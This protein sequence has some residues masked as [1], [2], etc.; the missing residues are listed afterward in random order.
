MSEAD[1]L[2]QAREARAVAEASRERVWSGASFIRDLF[3]GRFRLELIESLEFQPPTRPEFIQ[4]MQTLRGFLLSSVDPVEIDATG[5]Y[6][7]DVIQ[8]LRELGAFGL[9]IPKEYGGLGMSH[10]E[11][12]HVM[13]LLGSH[14]ANVTAL[15]SAHQAIGVPQPV[16]LF[17][18]EAQ[19]RQF[20]PR[21][22]KGAIS[23]FALTE[24]AVGSD[25]ARIQSR[26]ALS[27]D[28]TH[29]ILDGD[30]LWCTNGTL[31][32]LLVVMARDPETGRIN[33]F[34]VETSWPGVT[35]EYRCRFM[36][37]RAL[38]NAY[39]TFRQVRV[40]REN[41]IGP[42]GEGLRVALTTL[43]TGRLT[44]PAATAGGA[45][46]CVEIVRKWSSAR[47]Q[48][49]QE[50][51]KHEAVALLNAKI[52]SSALAMESV[53][54]AVGEIAD[55]E[56]F[57]IRLEAAAA[58]EWNTVRAWHLIDDTLQVRGGRG[59]ETELSLAARGEPAIGVERAL[60][61]ARIN[62]I[63][64]GSSEIMHLFMAREAVD[65][66]LEV[67]GA[68]VDP[69]ASMAQRLAALP[70]AIGFY[71]WWYPSRWIGWGR[72][73][74]YRG[75]GPLAKHLRF[76]D[77]C[78][79]R[80]ARAV[81]HGMAVYRAKLEHRQAFLFR[82]VDVAMELFVVTVTL[83]RAQLLHERDSSA[84]DGVLEL[85]DLFAAGARERIRQHLRG[86][87]HNADSAGYRVGRELL[88]GRYEW[89]ERGI[90]GI[91]EQADELT[92]MSLEDLLAEHAAPTEEP[93]PAPEPS[94]QSQVGQGSEDRRAG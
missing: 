13:A 30:K 5:E 34:V 88:A 8:G 3:M 31:A 23:A 92:P 64:E 16:L 83:R 80:L 41:L 82:A 86:L 37:L 67:A 63:F 4:F 25:P 50:I 27:D 61:D 2:I 9:K 73:P 1:E 66:H 93:G 42:V 52:A 45:K 44:L 40:P 43:N 36:G 81:F 65:E 51:G 10:I 32:E 29:Y 28:H 54:H 69:G 17:G 89:L 47:V 57:D 24:P 7:P 48:W 60:R 14:D 46:K 59:Y 76:V 70:R 33:A 85:A 55:R 18:T 78:C 21:C 56:Q 6:P 74:R 84:S 87:W 39:I 20:L 68:L 12:V 91:A 77:R 58:K 11:Y 75:Y 72:W 90:I 94:R 26:A 22:A 49:G 71:A 15:L 62:T 53:A 38:A 79:R 19:K 35:V